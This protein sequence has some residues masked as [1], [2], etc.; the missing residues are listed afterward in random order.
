MMN[1]GIK[2]GEGT[3]GRRWRRR[4]EEPRGLKRGGGGEGKSGGRKRGGVGGGGGQF[5][6]ARHLALTGARLT[7]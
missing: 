7:A 3:Q 4:C 1:G 6:V 2:G 5:G